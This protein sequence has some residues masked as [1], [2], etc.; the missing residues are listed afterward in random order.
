MR[1]VACAR[2]LRAAALPAVCATSVTCAVVLYAGA[3]G[4]LTGG[5]LGASDVTQR[6]PGQSR[7]KHLALIG[8]APAEWWLDSTV[9][10]AGSPVLI[11]VS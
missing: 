6:P 10:P 5:S 11:S 3:F 8:F 1:S 4:D 9:W 2:R 7:L